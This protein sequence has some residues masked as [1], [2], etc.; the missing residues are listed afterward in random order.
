MNCM[1]TISVVVPAYNA[2]RTILRCLDSLVAQGFAD[3]PVEVVVVNDGSTDGTAE[4]LAA[5]TET[6]ANVYVVN[7]ENGGPSRARNIGLSHATGRWVT[8]CD[9]DDWVDHGCYRDAVRIA[10]RRGAGI[11]V[12]GYKN[13]RPCSTRTHAWKVARMVDTSELAKRCLLDPNVQGFSCNK[14]YL[15]ELVTRESFPEDVR[16]CEDLIFNIAR[17]ERNAGVKVV[18]VPGAP[19][20]YDLSGTSLTR[21]GDAGGAAKSVLASIAE[22]GRFAPAARGAAYSIAVKSAYQTMRWGVAPCVGDLSCARDFYLSRFCPLTE[23]GKVAMRRVMVALGSLRAA[24]SER[25][26]V[27][28]PDSGAQGQQAGNRNGRR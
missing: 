7:V 14:L 26:R 28:G 11:A 19:Y 27:Q 2:E 5:Y 24:C 13:V 10:E 17:C 21:G 3:F 22:K 18:V 8:F 6:H 25:R 9:S 15:R 23:K 4:K 16:V 1:P 20:N 12:F